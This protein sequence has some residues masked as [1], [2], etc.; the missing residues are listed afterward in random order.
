MKKYDSLII[1]GSSGSGKT[2]LVNGLRTSKFA[3]K[4]V[5]P[6]RYITRPAR[7]GDDTVENRHVSREAF[8]AG[9]HDGVISPHWSRTLDGSRVEQYGFDKVDDNRLRV[10]SANNAFLRDRNLSVEAV[11]RSGL[12]VQHH[13]FRDRTKQ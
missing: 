8:T 11:L 7:Q 10:Y 2:T 1:V 5:I 9:V 13:G 3:S 6:A 12:V 4:I